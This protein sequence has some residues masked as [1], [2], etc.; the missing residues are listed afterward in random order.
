MH[1]MNHASTLGSLL[2]SMCIAAPA[3]AKND[4]SVTGHVAGECRDITPS[5]PGPDPTCWNT[6]KMDEWIQSW[7]ES[8]E[9]RNACD[10]RWEPWGNCLMRLAKNGAKGIDCLNIYETDGCPLPVFGQVVREPVE[11]WYATWSIWCTFPVL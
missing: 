8:P 3:P 5:A 2:F 1:A 6:L 4:I 7:M 9:T 11:L 10:T